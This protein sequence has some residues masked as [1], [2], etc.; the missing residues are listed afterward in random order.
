MVADHLTERSTEAEL[1]PRLRTYVEH[2]VE[3]LDTIAEQRKHEL[4]RL[5]SFIRT[6]Q[7]SNESASLTFICTHNSRRSH[8]GQLWGA[9]AAAWYGVKDVDTFSGGTEATAFNPRAVAAL[10]RAGF[11]IEN[12]GG[13]NPHY[14]VTYG[15]EAPVLE[16][17]SKTYDDPSNPQHGFAAVMTCSHADESCPVVMGAAVRVALPYD[18]PKEADGTPEEARRYDERCKQIATEMVYLFSQVHP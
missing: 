10:Q 13:D 18:D 17:F 4:R 11:E 9:A 3:E 2:V 16:S 7:A 12:P 6:K 5:A 14:R 15:P 1:H 8:M